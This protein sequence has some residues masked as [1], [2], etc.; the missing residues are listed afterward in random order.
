MKAMNA[1]MDDG[2]NQKDQFTSIKK[3]NKTTI[4]KIFLK[5]SKSTS[6]YRNRHHTLKVYIQYIWL[7]QTSFVPKDRYNRSGHQERDEKNSNHTTR[8]PREESK[9]DEESKI[10]GVQCTWQ[11]QSYDK[12]G[13][14]VK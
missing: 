4:V 2:V 3:R 14:S 9:P 11:R 1:M 6:T 7:F 10:T 8:G 13:R 12:E 5:E